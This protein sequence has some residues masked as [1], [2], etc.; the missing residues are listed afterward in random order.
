MPQSLIDEIIAEA[1][2]QKVKPQDDA[3]M[4]RT[5]P[6]LR[7]QLKSLVARDI[8]DMSEYFHIANDQNHIDQKGLEV[9]SQ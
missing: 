2:K 9:I 7:N 5:L 4:K 8:W 3:E 1:D 6:Y